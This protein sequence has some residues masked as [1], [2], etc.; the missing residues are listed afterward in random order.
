MA[1]TP[2]PIRKGIKKLKSFEKERLSMQ[3]KREGNKH[4]EIKREAYH[5]HLG[6]KKIKESD[7]KFVEDVAAY[8]KAKS[9]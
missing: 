1:A 6:K 4:A 9:K 8:K 5:K 3:T 2:K 7:K